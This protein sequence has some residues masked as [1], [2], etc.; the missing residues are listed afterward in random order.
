MVLSHR[1]ALQVGRAELSHSEDLLF[2][3]W[4]PLRLDHLPHYPLGDTEGSDRRWNRTPRD[5]DA[6]SHRQELHGTARHS[7]NAHYFRGLS[8]PLKQETASSSPTALDDRGRSFH[9]TRVAYQN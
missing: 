3:S 9:L 1:L 7:G 6:W 8:P 4:N 2:P 5:P